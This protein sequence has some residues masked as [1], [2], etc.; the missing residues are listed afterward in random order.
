[1]T[2]GPTG[3][4]QVSCYLRHM[5]DLFEVLGLDYDK[6]NRSRV[7]KAIRESLAIPGDASCSQVWSQIKAMSQ[8]ERDS[9]PGSV[10]RLLG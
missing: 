10:S 9:I 6:P 1:M 3:E 5:H 4:S 7:D 8:S 2:D